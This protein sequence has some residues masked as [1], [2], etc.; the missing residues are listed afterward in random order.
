MWTNEPDW[1]RD[2]VVVAAIAGNEEDRKEEQRVATEFHPVICVVQGPFHCDCVEI[3]LFCNPA[4]DEPNTSRS[5]NTKLGCH[6]S[7]YVRRDTT[8]N[9]I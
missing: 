3:I 6:K 8:D 9:T 7:T 2:M 5:I 4:C 1:K